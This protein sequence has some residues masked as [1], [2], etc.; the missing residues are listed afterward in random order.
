MNPRNDADS[1]QEVPEMSTTGEPVS[2]MPVSELE[3][4]PASAPQ[5]ADAGKP[6]PLKAMKARAAAGDLA[7][8]L[9]LFIRFPKEAADFRQIRTI[10]RASIR[11]ASKQS[12]RRFTREVYRESIAF[13]AYVQMRLHT[14]AVV[15][16]AD[17]DRQVQPRLEAPSDELTGKILPQ[18]EHLMRLSM[19]LN[20][21]WATTFR[22]WRLGSRGSKKTPIEKFNKWH[23]DQVAAGITPELFP[24]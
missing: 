19:E 7:G 13:L 24:E 12:P 3:M 8:L 10:I 22:T 5:A 17:A 18:I 15:S 9:D 11:Q 20:Q 21:S 16:L 4:P 1:E 14:Y 23:D 6:D 2:E